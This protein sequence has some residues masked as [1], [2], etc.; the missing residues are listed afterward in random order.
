MEQRP[1]QDLPIE[2]PEW[3]FVFKVFFLTDPH[4]IRMKAAKSGYQEPQFS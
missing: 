4:T 3:V 2:T 1:T